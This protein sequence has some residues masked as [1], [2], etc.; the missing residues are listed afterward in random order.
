MLI[1]FCFLSLQ[2]R[3]ERE[4]EWGALGSDSETFVKKNSMA[5]TVDNTIDIDDKPQVTTHVY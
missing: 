2:A 4:D 3:K 5:R 1:M